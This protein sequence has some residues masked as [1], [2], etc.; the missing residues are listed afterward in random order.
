[1]VIILILLIVV[2][3]ILK[4]KVLKKEI[5]NNEHLSI[6]NQTNNVVN[7]TE[8][9]N[10][11]NVNDSTPTEDNSDDGVIETISTNT[12]TYPN[13]NKWAFLRNKLN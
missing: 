10:E 11:L 13:T 6:H 1:M 2:I 3:V 9:K 5:S 8:E 12:E 7:I 4:N